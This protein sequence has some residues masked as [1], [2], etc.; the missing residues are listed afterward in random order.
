MKKKILTLSTFM[1]IAAY[2]FAQ[3][4]VKLNPIGLLFGQIPISGE[5]LINDDMG[6]EVTVGY[7]FKKESGFNDVS[8]SSGLVSNVLF[9]YYFNPEKGGDK[10]YAFPYFRYVSRSFTFTDA[11][12][13][14]E[15]EST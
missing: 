11:T 14:S 15:I 8:K 10:F 12:N 4:E 1:L 3:I 5:Y 2:G 9:K 7:Y 13:N 6:A